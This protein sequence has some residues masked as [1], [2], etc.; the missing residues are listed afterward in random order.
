[1]RVVVTGGS[2]LLGTCV[3][4]ALAADRKVKHITSIDMRPPMVGAAKIKAVHADVR[5]PEIGRHFAGCDAV[6]HLAFVVTAYLPRAQFDSINVEGSKNVFR[7]AV[8]AGVKHVV[9][10]SSVAAYGVVSGHPSPIVEDTPRRPQPDFPYASAKQQVEAFLDGFEAEHR[11]VV[12]TRLR[13]GIVFGA[14]MDHPLG[15]WLKRRVVP[16]A[17]DANPMPLVWDEDVADAIVLALKKRA[18]GAFNLVSDDEKTIPELAR[19]AGMRV[20]KMPQAALRAGA[21]M[22]RV[23]Q[24]AGLARGLDPAWLDARGAAMWVSSRRAREELGWRPT[25]D[26]CVDVIR[27]LVEVAPAYPDPRLSLLFRAV[28]V[29]AKR[30]HVPDEARHVSAVV[31]LELTGPGGGDFTLRID[32]GRLEVTAEV[33]RPPTSTVTMSAALFRELLGGATDLFTAGTT[34]RMRVA[35]DPIGSMVIGGLI[36]TFRAQTA[37]PG[38]TGLAARGLGRLVGAAS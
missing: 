30:R 14:R 36:S 31:H 5:D 21:S 19:A 23:A 28:D 34:G 6:V 9:Y 15:R 22:L 26:T 27:R 8:T 18:P 7:A 17:G 12:V 25:C 29:A 38:P 1:M 4:R 20:V 2:G 3:L 10:T 33:P 32:R 35:G 37:A 16:W 13:P 24:K 11:D